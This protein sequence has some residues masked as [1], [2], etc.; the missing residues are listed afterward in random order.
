MQTW[1][2][3]DA[4]AWRPQGGGAPR[5]APNYFNTNSYYGGQQNYWN[6][7]GQPTNFWSGVRYQYLNQNPDAVYSMFTSPFAGGTDPYSSW[8]RN[9]YGQMYDAYRGA[10][11]LNPDLTFQQYLSDFGQQGFQQRFNAQAPQQRGITPGQYGG[12]RVQWYT[13]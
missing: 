3:F 13:Y 2:P 6:N 7:G 8:V 12:G 10:L 4:G 1:N 11:S 5:S 9:Q